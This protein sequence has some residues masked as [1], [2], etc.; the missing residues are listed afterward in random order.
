MIF[1]SIT[2]FNNFQDPATN[3]GNRFAIVLIGVAIAYISRYILLRYMNKWMMA[4]S[5]KVNYDSVE[6]EVTEV[7][8]EKQIT[9]N[10]LDINSNL[11]ETISQRAILVKRAKQSMNEQLISDLF[12]IAVYILIGFYLESRLYDN[13][14]VLSYFLYVGLFLIW[15]VMRYV[16]YRHQFKAYQEGLFKFIAPIW[17]F[18]FAVFQSKWY[19]LLAVVVLLST[20]IK[21][22]FPLIV[23][24]VGEGLIILSAVAFHLIMIFRNRNKSKQRPNLKLIILRVFL[25]SKTSMFT[26]SKMAKFWKH[27]GTYFTVADPSFYRVFWK[28]NF[29]QKFPVIIVLIFLIYTQMEN[30]DGPSPFGPFIFLMIIAAIIF[31]ALGIRKMKKNFVSHEEAL[32][33]DLQKLKRHPVK[34]DKTFKEKPV[35]CYDNTW[36]FTVEKLVEYADVA[37]M[38]LRGFS[39]KNK[40]CE[41]EVN[42]LLNKVSISKILFIGYSDAIPLINNVIKEK[43]KTLEK[44]SPNY[45]VEK[46]IATVFNVDK[47]NDKEIQQIMDLLIHKALINN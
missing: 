31:I 30:M 25:I 35:S 7:Q 29:K 10:I 26:F 33:R 44:A 36:K 20:F 24:S 16:G 3:L 42:L 6:E 28:N 46:P 32:E 41:Y 38:D 15:T 9:F 34:L 19:M 1:S 17:K 37:L 22:F 11:D 27:F 23:G 47:E 43:F 8:N 39:E 45:N 18:I 40:G 4:K 21:G 14:D 2:L 5:K 12:V 13:S